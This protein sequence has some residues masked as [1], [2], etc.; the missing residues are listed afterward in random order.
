MDTLHIVHLAA[1]TDRMETLRRELAVQEITN[2]RI[3]PGIIGAPAYKGVAS[4][5]HQIVAFADEQQLES[6]VIAEDDIQFTAPGAYQYFL[7]HTPADYDLYLGGITWGSF[8]D[9]KRTEKFA[10]LT[11]YKIH[12]RFYQTFLSAGSDDHLDRSLSR[13]GTFM[14]CDPLVAKQYPGYS[15]NEGRDVNYEHHVAHMRFLE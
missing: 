4:A 10:G 8:G 9:E 1:R 3:W 2:Y 11:L 13:L 12:Q 7:E 15:D 6:V 5:H 14:I